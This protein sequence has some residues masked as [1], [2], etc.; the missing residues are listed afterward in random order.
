MVDLLDLAKKFRPYKAAF[1]QT[2]VPWVAPE[3]YLN[4]IFRPASRDVLPEIGAKVKIPEPFLELLAR[5]NGAIL[6][7]G[8]L[9]LYGVLR[10]AKG[11]TEPIDFR[12]RRST[13]KLTIGVGRRLTLTGF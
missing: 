3:A 9:S 10:K 5:N 7:S 12:Y 1:F 13:L 6:L 2:N 4:I 8:A 11:S